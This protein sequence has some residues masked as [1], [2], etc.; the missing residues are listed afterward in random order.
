MIYN[1]FQIGPRTD[2]SLGTYSTYKN[3]SDTDNRMKAFKYAMEEAF[4]LLTRSLSNVVLDNALKTRIAG[5]IQEIIDLEISFSKIITDQDAIQTMP[6]EET[7]EIT[8]LKRLKEMVPQVDWDGILGNLFT[9]VGIK[10]T[11]DEPIQLLDP[12]FFLRVGDFV[13]NSSKEYALLLTFSR[14]FSSNHKPNLIMYLQK[15][16]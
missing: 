4:Y 3:I 14:L 5:K 1:N 13:S 10:I 8:T 7:Y 9:G 2:L 12:L 15:L 6:T 16:S 11:D